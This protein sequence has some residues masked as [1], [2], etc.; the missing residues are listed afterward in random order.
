M[1]RSLR[2]RHA[3]HLSA[4]CL[5]LT[6]G[7]TLARAT[8]GISSKDST[9]STV[10]TAA[11]SQPLWSG[12]ALPATAEAPE[13]TDVWCSVI[14]PY[15]FTD[16]GYRFLHGVAL[17]WH[18][19]RLYAS[20]GHNKS[21][22]NTGGEQA[23]GCVSDDGGKT[24]GEIFT[25]DAGDPAANLSVSH[26]VFLSHGDELYAF[27]GCF[28]G[29]M[30]RV[31]T[32][33]YRLS[34]GDTSWEPLGVVV[35]GGFWPMQEPQQLA[36]GNWIMAGFRV[37]GGNP[38]AVA[39]SD[40]DDLLSWQL[41]PLPKE[42]DGMWGEST[43]LLDQQQTAVTNIARWGER[44]LALTAH[45]GDSGLSWSASQPSNLPMVTSKPYAG[46]LSTGEPYLIA[47]T[48]ADSG[49]R[50]SPL[51]IAIGLPGGNSFEQVFVIRHAEHD[52][53][54]ESHPKASL[55]Y[56][57]A[58]EHDGRLYVG[59]SNNGGLVGRVGQGRELANNNSAELAVIP[60]ASLRNA[61][62]N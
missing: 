13:L 27:H 15:A 17:C 18:H 33:A 44:P 62:A 58:I 46:R 52:G 32:R 26:G 22:E 25:I 34:D 6:C 41:I 20:F 31:H 28:Y 38:A 1:T 3:T 43:V 55:A 36:N 45:S 42:V 61:A 4:A 48:T 9:A 5:L 14:K 16:D 24:W 53:P 2:L 40:G 23:R 37:G 47:T 11:E 59:Y 8:D 10:T 21:P 19:G 60:L 51:T 35:D 49:K 39:I 57:Y 12:P 54:G 7:L 29:S 56:P 30:Q 50:R